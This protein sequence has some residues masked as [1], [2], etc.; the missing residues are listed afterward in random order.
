MTNTTKESLRSLHDRLAALHFDIKADDIYTSLT[1]A[2]DLVK[3][4]NLRPLLYLEDDAKEDFK[5]ARKVIVT[6]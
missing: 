3:S 1:A 5:G 6:T 2:R 4:R